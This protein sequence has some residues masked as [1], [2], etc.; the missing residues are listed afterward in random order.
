MNE[1]NGRD[2]S[3]HSLFL[4]RYEPVPEGLA[5]PQIFFA[6]VGW[7]TPWEDLGL[8]VRPLDETEDRDDA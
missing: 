1:A 5:D 4:A 7:D 3:R 6:D 8:T 2:D